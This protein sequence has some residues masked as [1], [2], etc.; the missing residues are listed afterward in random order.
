MLQTE[1]ERCVSMNSNSR[2]FDRNSSGVQSSVVLKQGY[3]YFT[4]LYFILSGELY[5][6]VQEVAREL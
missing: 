3:L 5:C 6:N 4:L 1:N 2:S